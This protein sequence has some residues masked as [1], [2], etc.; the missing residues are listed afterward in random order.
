MA[1]VRQPVAAE[2]QIRVV[3]VQIRYPLPRMAAELSKI[4]PGA[5]PDTSA[6]ST[7]VPLRRSARPQ[8]NA[9]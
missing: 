1:D 5:L 9:M 7:A 6:R 8:V 3:V 4:V 2:P